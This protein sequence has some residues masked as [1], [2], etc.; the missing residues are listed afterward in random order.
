[1]TEDN[2]IYFS[3]P[4]CKVVKNAF[5]LVFIHVFVELKNMGQIIMFFKKIQR[6]KLF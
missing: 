6:F 4:R 2:V 1:M 3:S 5:K